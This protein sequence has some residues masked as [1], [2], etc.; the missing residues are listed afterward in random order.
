[1]GEGINK[2]S[3]VL[4]LVKDVYYTIGFYQMILMEAG[5]SLNMALYIAYKAQDK[6][7][8]SELIDYTE[9]ELIVP[10]LAFIDEWGKLAYPLNQAYDAYFSALKK[11]CETYNKVLEKL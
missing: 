8:L 11:S 4:S 10:A 9:N 6:D 5:K 1:M 7:L 2:F 3:I